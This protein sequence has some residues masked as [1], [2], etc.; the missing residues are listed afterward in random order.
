MS[1]R[2]ILFIFILF[3]FI[4]FFSHSQQTDSIKFAERNTLFL[5]YDN[6]RSSITD[7]S[8]DVLKKLNTFQ[9]ELIILDNS[10]IHNY[11]STNT[12][13]NVELE[14]KCK[15][16]ENE[17]NT[18]IDNLMRIKKMIFY[19]LIIAGIFILLSVLFIV[20]YIRTNIKKKETLSQLIKIEKIKEE[21]LKELE[22]LKKDIASISV[23]DKIEFTKAKEELLADFTSLKNKFDIIIKEKELLESKLKDDEKAFNELNEKHN[24]LINENSAETINLK[25]HYENQ[26][27]QLNNELTQ[28]KHDNLLMDEKILENG[29]VVNNLS[30]Q[31]DLLN[32]QQAELKE[33]I[34]T[35]ELQN[36]L[37]EE[38]LLM[39][40]E[41]KN[42]QKGPDINE[43]EQL[44]SEKS[45]LENRLNE[46]K[47][48]LD[49]EKLK[50]Q[51]MLMNLEKEKLI[52]HNAELSKS[53]EENNL[54]R[55]EL[56]K[57]KEQLKKEA[58]LRNEI[59]NEIKQLIEEIKG[60]R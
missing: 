49:N 54:L 27:Y 53:M 52:E 36:K 39:V 3:S 30:N 48:E 25:N 19:G 11:I 47:N 7:S 46:I 16:L 56:F 58:Q 2:K 22:Q 12:K 13:K 38:K 28:I 24:L 8:I 60:S 55:T 57:Y 44:K 31:I 51:E 40:E 26:V 37:L 21:Q 43:F 14:G 10:L 6:Y 29:G 41:V 33:L 15:V 17:K 18:A 32:S 34:E 42:N 20:L 45:N 9:T 59:E 35:K 50:N 5:N 4:P 23:T 1:N